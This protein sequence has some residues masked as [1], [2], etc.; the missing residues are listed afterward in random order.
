MDTQA[1]KQKTIYELRLQDPKQVLNNLGL[2]Y[3]TVGYDSYK[4]KVRAENTASA[5]ISLKNGVWKYKDFGSGASGD[6][7][8]LVMDATGNDFKSALNYCLDQYN[9]PNYLE[10]AK[11]SVTHLSQI[12][13]DKI[14]QIKEQNKKRES[15]HALSRVKNVY[16]VSTNQLAVEY[17]KSRGIT[18]I[19]PHFKV[20]TGEY[21][22]KY[23]EVKK[24][25]GV[26][27]LTVDKTGADIHFLK[28]IGDLK[29]MSFGQKDISFFKNED[30]KKVAIFESKM[31]Y[32]AAYQQINLDKVNVVIA[33]S[34]SNAIKVVSFLK[35]KNLTNEIMF[36]NQ[37]DLQCYQF[38]EDIAK[39][40]KLEEFKTIKYNILNEYKKDINDLILKDEKI[41]DRIIQ[42]S[43][44]QIASITKS[45]SMID[46]V[47]KTTQDELKK[48]TQMIKSQ[49]QSKNQE[50]VR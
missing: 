6:I 20:I 33:N 44:T 22:N 19:P 40:L 12:N 5:F 30:S 50:N 28:Q 27:V 42:S 36:F 13:K 15:S 48:D 41:A 1:L 10:E 23:G 37:N 26:G 7:V 18:K 4:L 45:L 9:I 11:E 46:N 39:G 25:F 31:D 24:A 38:V 8:T 49:T 16:E 34:T 43:K 32:A 21:T 17:L 35:E 3:K 29:T 2:E 14:K 47:Y